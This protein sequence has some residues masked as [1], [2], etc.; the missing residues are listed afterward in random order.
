MTL[1]WLQTARGFRRVR[2]L[3]LSDR[4]YRYGMAVFETLRVDRGRVHFLREHLASLQNACALSGFPA[5]DFSL[6]GDFL[7]KTLRLQQSGVARIHVTA[8]DGGPGDPPRNCRILLGFEPRDAALPAAYRLH[9]TA[10]VHE[11]PFRGLKTHNYWGQTAALQAAR[12]AGCDE[13]LLFDSG[14]ALISAAMA[15]VFVVDETGALFTPRDARAGILRAWVCSRRRVTEG[16][17][18]RQTFQ[19]AK[20]VFLTNSWIGV[21]PAGA[22]SGE[23]AAKLR[24]ELQAYYDGTVSHP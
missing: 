17:I 23:V 24:S 7:L 2:G 22:L 14:G 20:E 16:R 3:P 13:A 8:G 1:H 4:G 12:A 10:A 6:A 11:I 21:M 18:D 19:R 15:N 5:L 9:M